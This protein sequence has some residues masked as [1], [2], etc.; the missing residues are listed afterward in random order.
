M[1]PYDIIGWCLVAC[2]ILITVTTG[3]IA[4]VIV[5]D[6]ARE[7]RAAA[8]RRRTNRRLA[9]ALNRRLTRNGN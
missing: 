2:A 8:R 9:A 7:R 3:Y 4:S 1:N 6:K 5:I